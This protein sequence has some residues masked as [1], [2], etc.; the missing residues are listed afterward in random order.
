M[1]SGLAQIN[2]DG[3]NLHAMILRVLPHHATSHDQRRTISLVDFTPVI[4]SAGVVR[5]GVATKM[6]RP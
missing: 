3:S 2:A 5:I 6:G 4:R 1:E